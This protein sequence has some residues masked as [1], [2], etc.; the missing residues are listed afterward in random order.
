[1]K[2]YKII[3]TEEFINNLNK[4]PVQYHNAIDK[5]LNRLIKNPFL[6]NSRLKDSFLLKHEVSKFRILYHVNGHVLEIWTVY[7]M[8][9][10]ENYKNL[11]KIEK[12]FENKYPSA[13]R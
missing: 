5:A 9:R 8:P 6:S 4:I 13:M 1:M 11:N 12:G 2:I 3:K 7:L 10:K